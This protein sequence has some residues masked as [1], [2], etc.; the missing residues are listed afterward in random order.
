[1]LTRQPRFTV[2]YRQAPVLVTGASG[3]IGSHLVASLISNGYWVIGADHSSPRRSTIAMRNLSE[4]LDHPRFR[5]VECDLRITDVTALLQ[6]VSTVF[7]LAGVSGVRESWGARFEDY[8]TV[9][10]S[11]RSGFWKHAVQQV[12]SVLC[13]L[14]RRACTALPLVARL[15]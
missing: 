12:S 8:A 1:M 10:W 9:N 14:R 11:G 7:H 3:F 6:D 2:P 5:F 4:V 15:E 13:S